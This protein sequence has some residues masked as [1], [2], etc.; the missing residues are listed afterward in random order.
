[1]LVCPKCFLKEN[2]IFTPTSLSF[3][4]FFETWQ[5]KQ[6]NEQP[7]FL[8]N[9]M[10]SLKML[11]FLSSFQ[12]VPWTA[13][14]VHQSCKCANGCCSD[15][16]WIIWKTKII[17]NWALTKTNQ[18]YIKILESD[19]SSAAQI[20]AVIAHGTRHQARAS[21]TWMGSFSAS[22]LEVEYISTFQIVYTTFIFF[23]FCYSY[24]QLVIGLCVIQFRE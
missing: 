12:S 13:F 19:R 22:S 8:A 2:S 5:P 11:I 20:W 21:C 9:I 4:F 16:L 18:N 1:M 14:H 10:L 6:V 24:D 15:I 23:E 17:K 3:P 7:L